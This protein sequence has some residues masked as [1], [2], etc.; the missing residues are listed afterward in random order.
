[1]VVEGNATIQRGSSQVQRY[2]Y[3]CVCVSSRM[4][5]FE[6]RRGTKKKKSEHARFVLGLAKVTSQSESIISTVGLIL[7]HHPNSRS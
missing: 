7:L 4:N 1:M 3:I 6:K 5:V 2:K